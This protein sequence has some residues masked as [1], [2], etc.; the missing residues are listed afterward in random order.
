MAGQDRFE[1]STPAPP[2]LL[3]E[4][5]VLRA[6]H[7]KSGARTRSLRLRC[8]VVQIGADSTS[9][10]RG[11]LQVEG[12]IVLGSQ[13]NDDAGA[14]DAG[15]AGAVFVRLT[16]D[17]V[18]FGTGAEVEAGSLIAVRRGP[19]NYDYAGVGSRCTPSP[20]LLFTMLF[21]TK[22]APMTHSMPCEVLLLTRLAVTSLS[23]EPDP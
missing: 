20:P 11:L 16:V 9:G 3:R 22:S 12:R 8:A 10:E 1:I 17:E 13:V 6:A 7:A 15:A 18:V 4:T 19:G 5:R 21:D 2:A 23:P 14:R